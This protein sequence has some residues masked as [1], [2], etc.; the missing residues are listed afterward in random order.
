MSFFSGQIYFQDTLLLQGQEATKAR[1]NR[2]HVVTVFNFPDWR[3]EQE[4]SNKF[5]T[6]ILQTCAKIIT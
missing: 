2:L 6:T 1:M 4:I 3:E 5:S